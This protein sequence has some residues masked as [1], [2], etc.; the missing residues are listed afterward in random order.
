MGERR[1]LNACD[2]QRIDWVMEIDRAGLRA[3]RP[4]TRRL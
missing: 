3:R 2:L 4:L 1:R